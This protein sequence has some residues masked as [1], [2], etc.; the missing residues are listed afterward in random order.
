MTTLTPRE[1]G[2]YLASLEPPISDAQAEA[3]ARILVTAIEEVA[4]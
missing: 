4:A 2:A 3:A 1:Y